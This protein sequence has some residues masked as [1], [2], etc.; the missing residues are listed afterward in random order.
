MEAT[1]WTY[2][3][4]HGKGCP[5]CRKAAESARIYATVTGS[6]SSTYTTS[7]LTEEH[8]G[9]AARVQ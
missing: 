1:T 9:T 3:S 2:T 6:V 7:Y 5:D 8:R 4:T